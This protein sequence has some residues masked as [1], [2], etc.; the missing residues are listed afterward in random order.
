M[1]NKLTLVLAAT[2]WCLS[3]F[4]TSTV[5]GNDSPTLDRV[6]QS[7]TLRIGLSGKQP[8]L[9]LRNAQGELVGYEVE[10]ARG[11]AGAMGVRTEFVLIP[12]GE[13]LNAL[14]AGR[15]D[16]VM[17][18]MAI[19]AERSRR[20]SFIGPYLM[21]GKSVLTRSEDLA[22]AKSSAAFNRA[23]YRLA[24][25]ENSTSQRFVELVAPEAQLVKVRDYDEGV[26]K[27]IENEVDGLIADMPIGALAL[28]RYP[29]MNL[30]TSAK[31]LSV[32]PLGIAVKRGDPAFSEVIS[33]FVDAYRGMGILKRLQQKY[34]REDNWI[35]DTKRKSE[36]RWPTY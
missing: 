35:V 10:L 23:E 19:T 32:E 13:L 16:M 27:V 30:L 17:S 7:G 15:I 36:A 11:I 24:A 5:S 25:L 9:N 31:P 12:F 3:A 21:S 20:A 4:A 26:R 14:D 34:L 29:D 8:P 22:A 33:N 6:L 18:G 2:L 28:L 1:L